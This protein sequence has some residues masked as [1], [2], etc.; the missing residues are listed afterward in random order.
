MSHSEG[1]KA[2]LAALERSPKT[3]PE[4]VTATGI[5]GA[6]LGNCIKALLLV[7]KI[8]R[9]EIRKE[10]FQYYIGLTAPNYA[11]YVPVVRLAARPARHNAYTGPIRRVPIGA[12]S[13]TLPAF[14]WEINSPAQGQ[15]DPAQPGNPTGTRSDASTH[16][17]VA[18]PLTT[19]GA[20][21][22]L[23]ATGAA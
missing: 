1:C 12:V 22:P 23:P 8:S 19:P 17:V 10:R 18:V 13:V 11:G 9:V 6:K 7:G 4:L 14:P 15:C 2:V 3:T 21:N 16:A 20:L 5:N